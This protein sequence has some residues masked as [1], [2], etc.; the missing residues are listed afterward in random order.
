MAQEWWSH[1]GNA[2]VHTAA[3]VQEW[4]ATHNVQVIWPLP[5]SLDLAPADI[6][7][8]PRVKEQLAGL[9]LDRNKIKMWE[10]V[11]RAIAPEEFA[12]TFWQRYER[13][14]KCIKIS[15]GDVE[16]S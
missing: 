7:L 3:M 1:W 2:P 5:Y 13:C 9:T 11:T 14:Q 10:G 15:G 16:K 6:F 8:F 4:L 12:T